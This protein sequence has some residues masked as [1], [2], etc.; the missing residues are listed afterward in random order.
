MFVMIHNKIAQAYRQK[1]FFTFANPVVGYRPQK[2]NPNRIHITAM[3]NLIMYDSELSVRT[4]DINTEKL[5]WKIVVITPN[6]KYMCLNLKICYLS[7]ALEY[8]EFMKMPLSLFPKWIVEQYDLNTH[9]QDGWVHLEMRHAVWG[10]PQAGIITNKRLR[11]KFAPFGYY[12]CANTPGRWYHEPRQ[13]TFTLVVDNFG[14]KYVK[15]ED[16]DHLFA[17]LKTMYTGLDR[18]SVLWHYARVGL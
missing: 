15:K 2:D 12:E 10:L 1:K 9:A 6:A 3:G 11:R 17:S 7:A 8:F 5:H 16:V 18:H 4:A 13:I 14:V